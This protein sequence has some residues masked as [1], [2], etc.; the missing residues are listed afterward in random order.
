MNPLFYFVVFLIVPAILGGPPLFD[1]IR[2]PLPSTQQRIFIAI[3][4]F[5]LAG[6]V[7]LSF[8]FSYTLAPDIKV[9]SF[10]FPSLTIEMINGAWPDYANPLSPFIKIW[11]VLFMFSMF[12]FLAMMTRKV[13]DAKS[14][15]MR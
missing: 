5:V 10:P 7:F 11:N 9:I 13:L 6:S 14:T 4:A 3:S 12:L 2:N 15:K 8:F 1:L